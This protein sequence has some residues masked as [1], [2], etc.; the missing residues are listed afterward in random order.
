MEPSKGSLALRNE[1]AS[2]TVNKIRVCLSSSYMLFTYIRT[3]AESVRSALIRHK[4]FIL[5]QFRRFFGKFSGPSKTMTTSQT[6]ADISERLYKKK[7]I[8]APMVRAVSSHL[9]IL[10][11]I[12]INNSSHKTVYFTASRYGNKQRGRYS[13]YR[14]DCRSQA[15]T[16]ET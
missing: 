14:G 11:S 15:F 4:P 12:Q 9:I 1:L 8:L 16:C 5:L 7:L 3:T 6:V 10:Y 13:I 2:C